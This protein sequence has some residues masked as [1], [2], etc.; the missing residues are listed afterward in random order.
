[1]D[2]AEAE[3]YW[4]RREAD[5]IAMAEAQWN[6][7]A[8]TREMRRLAEETRWLLTKPVVRVAIRGGRIYAGLVTAFGIACIALADW[9]LYGTAS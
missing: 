6:A 4:I 8:A 3:A 1:M 9:T 5:R 2:L 7:R